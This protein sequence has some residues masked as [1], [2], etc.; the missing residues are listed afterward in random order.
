MKLMRRFHFVVG[1][2]SLLAA[3]GMLWIALSQNP[4]QEF[5]GSELGVDWISLFAIGACTLV[6]SFLL[7]CAPL[8]LAL[9]ITRIFQKCFGNRHPSS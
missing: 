5:Y 2:V 8:W 9:G 3:I 4:Q 1:L 6:A 7:L